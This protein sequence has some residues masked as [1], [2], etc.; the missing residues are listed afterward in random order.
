MPMPI[1]NPYIIRC[2]YMRPGEQPRAEFLNGT[3]SQ[4][5]TLL[6]GK[7]ASVGID[8]GICAFYNAFS[9]VM[10]MPENRTI[11]NHTFYG[12]IL[13]VSYNATGDIFDLNDG[14]FAYYED[15]LKL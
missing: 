4:M 3:E 2:L 7:I 15:L 8:D 14:D 1:E 12:P 6:D 13:L 9:E 5:E 10:Q 11:G